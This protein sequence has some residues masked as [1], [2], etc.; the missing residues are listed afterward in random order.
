[1]VLSMILTSRLPA[2][3]KRS[4]GRMWMGV[5][6]VDASCRV[7]KYRERVALAI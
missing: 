5:R 6:W 2:I 7:L 1:M 3:T 4:S